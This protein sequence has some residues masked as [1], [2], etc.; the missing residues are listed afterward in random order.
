MFFFYFLFK[1]CSLKFVPLSSELGEIIFYNYL[2]FKNLMFTNLLFKHC[3]IVLKMR[4]QLGGICDSYVITIHLLLEYIRC[5]LKYTSFFILN[6]I[7]RLFT[8]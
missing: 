2:L 7:I 5:Y 4:I 1:S 3:L 6:I 8:S